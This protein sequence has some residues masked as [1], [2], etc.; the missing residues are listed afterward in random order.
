M[1]LPESQ[2][3]HISCLRH[4]FKTQGIP[5]VNMLNQSSSLWIPLKNSNHHNQTSSEAWS[6]AIFCLPGSHFL[7]NQLSD[8]NPTCEWRCHRVQMHAHAIWMEGILNTS[9]IWNQKISRKTWLHF[10]V[11]IWNLVVLYSWAGKPSKIRPFSIKTR[12]PIWVP[13]GLRCIR[14]TMV[15]LAGNP[16]SPTVIR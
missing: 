15:S 2:D 9:H 7:S 12:G 16:V 6:Q 10:P 1:L 8:I 13:G 11:Y 4:S 14:R 3:I 5:L